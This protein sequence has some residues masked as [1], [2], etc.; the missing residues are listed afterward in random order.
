MKMHKGPMVGLALVLLTVVTGG[1]YGQSARETLMRHPEMLRQHPPLSYPMSQYLRN[2]PEA[3]RNLT[4]PVA[5]PSSETGQAPLAVPF[6]NAPAPKSDP[7][8]PWQ[9]LTNPLGRIPCGSDTFLTCNA[10][11][12]LLL[13]DGTVIVHISE[14]LSVNPLTV[15]ET[16]YWWRLTPDINGSYLNGTWS[17]IA[18]LPI[19]YAPRFFASAVLPD[20]RVIVE[21]GEYNNPG[22]EVR[23]NLG[24]IY[25]PIA[26]KWTS[27]SP[28]SGWFHIGDAQSVVLPDGT[29]MLANA[30]TKE[31]ALLNAGSLNWTPT[32]SGKFDSNNEEGWTLLWN[33]DLLTVDAY[34]PIPGVFPGG[35]DTN[36][37]RYLTSVGSWITA[38]STIQQLPD[39]SG[40]N[41]SYELG[42]QVLRPDG[43]VI[44]F[45]GT[46]SGVAHTAIFN[47]STLTW[48]LVPI[49]RQLPVGITHSPTLLRPCFRAATCCSPRAPDSL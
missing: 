47:S 15:R 44:A 35:C 14:T 37:E 27:V 39:C 29:F 2:N 20:G 42:P 6:E 1:A 40:P 30:V 12:P 49:C 45:G 43:T 5:P 10:S 31:Q 24:A 3:S 28:P 7:A 9:L 8:S 41:L 22:G 11:N 16:P 18:S 33:G 34:V 48:R 21:G 17:P 26:N 23:T 32:G 25:D 13:T 4:S 36:S 38:G 46:T 19:G